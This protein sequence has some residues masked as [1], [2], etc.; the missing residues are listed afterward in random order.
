MDYAKTGKV[1]K[2]SKSLKI[3]STPTS[4]KAASGMWEQAVLI[5]RK[6]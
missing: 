5:L 4:V 2:K 3:V 6:R 1:L